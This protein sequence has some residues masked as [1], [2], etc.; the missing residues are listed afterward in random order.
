MIYKRDGSM[1]EAR[2]ERSDISSIY[3]KGC[4]NVYKYNQSGKLK[5]VELHCND[6][7]RAEARKTY[8][9]T[10]KGRLKNV[11]LDICDDGTVD[12]KLRYVITDKRY[13]R[14]TA[15]GDDEVLDRMD[16]STIEDTPCYFKLCAGRYD[17]VGIPRSEIESIDHPG[18]AHAVISSTFA[19]TGWVLVFW[20]LGCSLAC[21]LDDR[22]VGDME[23]A[24]YLMMLFGLPT[25]L[26]TTPVAIWHW[27]AW[28]RSR[29]AA[30]P[31]EGIKIGP[32]AFR[33]GERTYYGIGLGWRW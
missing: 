10:K 24:S 25:T 28:G 7:A 26:I 23:T 17:E 12:K 13:G 16:M 33:E 4:H 5:T 22:C 31:P 14:R 27:H 18:D 11:E 29:S 19:V 2:I 9:Y 3:V 20:S 8:T 30:A 6:D 21:K 1:V 32:L 15:L